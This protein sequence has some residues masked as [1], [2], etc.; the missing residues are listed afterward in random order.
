MKRYS[1]LAAAL[2]ACVGVASAQETYS[3]SA[4]AQQVL[5]LTDI[6]TATNERTCTNRGQAIGCTQ[7]QSC[8]GQGVVCANGSS[9][10]AAQARS[11]G[12]RIFP[13]TQAGREEYVTFQLV[14]PEFISRRDALSSWYQ[15]RQ[16]RFWVTANA[17]QRS[18][19]CTAAGLPST[20]RLCQ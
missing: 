1:L 14:G 3:T 2:F 17:S 12:A 6:V 7:A 11:C 18:A 20:C 16:C 19:M 10:T 9:C 5:D 15:E 4:T 13:L 8:T